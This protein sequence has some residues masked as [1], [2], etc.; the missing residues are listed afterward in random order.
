M[1]LMGIT[2]IIIAK[3]IFERDKLHGNKFSVKLGLEKFC[4]AAVAER[5][6]QVRLES[7][8]FFINSCSMIHVNVLNLVV[9]F[10]VRNIIAKP[11]VTTRTGK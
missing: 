7:A 9:K 10:P 2:E 1:V 11:V 5:F 6:N 8:F 3:H 4:E